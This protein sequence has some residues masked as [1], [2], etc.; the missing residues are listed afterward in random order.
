M[1]DRNRAPRIARLQ[2]GLQPFDLV[3]VT[4]SEFAT[5]AMTLAIEN[6][7][8]PAFNVIAIAI[9]VERPASVTPVLVISGHLGLLEFV[10]S[11]GGVGAMLVT[12]PRRFIAVE[13][14]L[15]AAVLVCRRSYK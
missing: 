7:D 10:I 14:L 9:A 8:V 11:H 6:D 13:I 5:D 4:R 1:P 3:A 12:T 15:I 2:I